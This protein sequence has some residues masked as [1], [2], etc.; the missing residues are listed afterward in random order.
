[1]KA[2]SRYFLDILK[3]A[4]RGERV[5]PEEALSAE[6]WQ[7]IIRLA[8]IHNVLPMVYEATYHL[9]ALQDPS[10]MAIRQQVRYQVTLQTVK[11]SE[12]LSLNRH[13][14]SAGIKPLVVKGIV[15]R[16]LYPTPDHRQ[17]ADED[18]LVPAEQRNACH[19]SMLSFG[20]QPAEPE[21]DMDAAYEIPYI[22]RGSALYIELHKHLFPPESE[23]YG[24][25][26]RFF[27]GVFDRAV[28]E[29][30]QNEPVLTMSPTDHLFYLICHSFKHFLH[31]GFGIRQVCDIVLYAEHYGDR[32]NWLQV[33]ENCR[34]IRA[35]KF[36]AA[37]FRIGEVYLGF[38]LAAAR[39]PACWREMEVD[40]GPMLE[41][42]LEAGVYG[43][44]ELSRRHS[45]TIT[46]TAVADQKQGHKER[47]G[48][49]VSLFPAAKSMEKRYPYL[50]KHPYLLPV[51]WG[52]RIIKYGRETKKARNNNAVDAV[53]IGNQ[54]IALMKQ[55][56]IL[57]D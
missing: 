15:C 18:V 33:L 3:A 31:S 21:T 51:A 14:R 13:L 50:K 57:D 19:E 9:P 35:D 49:L 44:A 10:F 43:G 40:E 54:R 32:I 37:M 38:D 47:S 2:Y 48:V 53:K 26:N 45:S 22:K 46:L 41:D 11:T 52:S 16:S 17:S 4:L 34:Q 24:D 30:I 7:R 36:A 28:E 12:F 25:L 56:G 8:Q 23:A 5:Q 29:Y 39:Y 6:D 55:Y 20:L 1:M 27:E 42:L